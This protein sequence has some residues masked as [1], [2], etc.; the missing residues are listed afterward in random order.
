MLIA[1]SNDTEP[2]G[3]QH[4][5]IRSQR[6]SSS[7]PSLPDRH[8]GRL[9]PFERKLVSCHDL[10]AAAVSLAGHQAPQQGLI[11]SEYQAAHGQGALEEPQLLEVLTDPEAG[12]FVFGDE[13]IQWRE[14]ALDAE[15]IASSRDRFAI[16]FGSCSFEEPLEDLRSLNLI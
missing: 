7:A 1:A 12:S 4:P 11:P 14:H 10:P 16:A 5:T 13:D 2:K 8:S 6:E 9:L 15:Q 3:K